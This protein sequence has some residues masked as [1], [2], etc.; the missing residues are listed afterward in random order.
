[1]TK[2]KKEIEPEVDQNSP[3][4][5]KNT[6]QIN[7]F[8]KLI[9]NFITAYNK[10]H[11]INE[12]IIFDH[13]NN[14]YYSL[15]EDVSQATEI[16]LK[17]K[18][19]MLFEKFMQIFDD[20]LSQILETKR[21]SFYLF[22]HIF[23]LSNL[24]IIKLY[25]CFNKLLNVECRSGSNPKCQSLILHKSLQALHILTTNQCQE[26]EDDESTVMCCDQLAHSFNFTGSLCSILMSNLVNQYEH[27]SLKKP[28]HAILDQDDI[29]ITFDL[30]NKLSID[31]PVL[32]FDADTKR[33]INYLI[34]RM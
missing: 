23:Q 21:D 33:L 22:I 3:D 17:K 7:L 1:M 9:I 20:F 4:P 14:E 28:R 34:E 27:S 10:Y 29:K 11:Q 8:N 5:S 32:S 31:N 13:Q 15:Y 24:N 26:Y 30:L 25:E 18:R 2:I 6:S 16:D 19:S 12:Q